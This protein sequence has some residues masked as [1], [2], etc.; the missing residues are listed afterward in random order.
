[1]PGPRYRGFVNRTLSYYTAR[2]SSF[3]F[4]AS[5]MGINCISMVVV[6][7]G[8][9]YE[10]RR[11]GM[12]REMLLQTLRKTDCKCSSLYGNIYEAKL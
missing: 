1:M 4:R 2:D 5:A 12:G 11:T 10:L 8:A 9:S 3:E 6:L 7:F